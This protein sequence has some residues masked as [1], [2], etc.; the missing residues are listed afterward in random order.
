MAT[1]Q[2]NTA[3]NTTQQTLANL[4]TNTSTS[5]KKSAT[6]G[7]ADN[8]DQFLKIL[9]TQ[10]KTQSPLEPLDSNEFTKQL[11][12]F[13]G[14]EQQLKTNDFLATMLATSRASAGSAAVSYIG[15]QI[16]ADGNIT[17]LA[18]S[19]AEW[20]F[21]LPKDAERAVVTVRDAQGNTVFTEEKRL[22]SGEN[23]YTWNGLTSNRTPA[24]DGDYTL[25]VEARDAGGQ[26]MRVT[27]E[28]KGV[29][30]SVDM[31]G[32]VP[33]LVLTNGTS[34]PVDKIKT[35]HKSTSL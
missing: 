10:L 27:M 11:T 6:A 32:D 33:M 2:T 17:R 21:S 3:S 9:T 22:N 23:S 16:S 12:Q 29:V 20:G 19:N 14:V 30:E 31:S 28:K 1:Q 34:L 18:N 26:V 4:G 25:S 5:K 8:F 35:I 13:A 7:I 24:P 15:H